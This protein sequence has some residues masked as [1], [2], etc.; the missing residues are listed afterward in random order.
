MTCIVGWANEKAMIMGGD[1]AAVGGYDIT[2]RDDPKVFELHQPGGPGVLIG[3][4][5]SFRMGQLLMTLKVPRDTR[6]NLFAFMVVDFIPVIRKLFGSGGFMVKEHG[7][8]EGGKFLVAYRGRIFTI[9]GDFQ[10]GMP[11]D[12]YDAIGCGEAY[13]LGVMDVLLRQKEADPQKVLAT[14]LE[15]SAKRSGGVRPPFRLAVVD[16]QGSNKSKRKRLMRRKK[17]RRK[18]TRNKKKR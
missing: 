13:A 18:N 9:D 14:A 11:S 5:G 12:N 8:E 6:E 16:L 4:A 7:R 15:V 1:S 2:I 3:F 17:K 10:V